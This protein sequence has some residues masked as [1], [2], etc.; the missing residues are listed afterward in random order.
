MRAR[1]RSPRCICSR[2]SIV[3]AADDLFGDIGAHVVRFP[4]VLLIPLLQAG[5]GEIAN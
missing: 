4:V 3:Y 1:M 5:L 2:C